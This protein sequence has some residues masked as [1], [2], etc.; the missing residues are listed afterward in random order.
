MSVWAASTNKTLC[1]KTTNHTR[2]S[3]A[4]IAATGRSATER[5]PPM[6]STDCAHNDPARCN[7]TYCNHF[8]AQGI[9]GDCGACGMAKAK[10]EEV[11]K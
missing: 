8:Q 3:I 7:G 9:K 5:R 1:A 4:S 6:L 10:E 11:E 2:T